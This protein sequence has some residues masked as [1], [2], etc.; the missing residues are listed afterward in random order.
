[1]SGPGAP[2]RSARAPRERHRRLRA[3]RPARRRRGSPGW[4]RL[5]RPDTSGARRPRAASRARTTT[6]RSD[7]GRRRGTRRTGSSTRSAVG[8]STSPIANRRT[9]GSTSSSRP[10]A[11]PVLAT[12]RQARL[13]RRSAPSPPSSSAAGPEPLPSPIG[14][15]TTFASIPPA[16][17]IERPVRNVG[18]IGGAAPQHRPVPAGRALAGHQQRSHGRVDP[19][20][21]DQNV[22]LDRRCRPET[23]TTASHRARPGQTRPAGGRSRSPPRPVARSTASLRTPC[24]A[25]RWIENCGT[26]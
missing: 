22:R 7:R 6:A 14:Y 8:T 2:A 16:M 19:V 17:I 18:P 24:N 1:M 4:R 20:G 5:S 23:S 9:C 10:G 11:R 26:G 12:W 3:G 25:P 13:R 21:A 15:S